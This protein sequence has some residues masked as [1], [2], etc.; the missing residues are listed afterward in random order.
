MDTSIFKETINVND[1][2]VKLTKKAEKVFEDNLPDYV[3]KSVIM[4]QTTYTYSDGLILYLMVNNENIEE[5]KSFFVLKYCGVDD[6]VYDNKSV[7]H[8]GVKYSRIINKGI[9]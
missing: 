7:S 4:T 9:N 8:I 6:V 1:E 2:L 5:V 3:R